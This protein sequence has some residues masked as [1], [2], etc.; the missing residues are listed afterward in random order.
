LL[1]S[2]GGLSA[3]RQIGLLLNSLVF[4]GTFNTSDSAK[5]I[6]S[7]SFTINEE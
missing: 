5:T 4:N 6:I 1:D 7:T 3:S 2:N